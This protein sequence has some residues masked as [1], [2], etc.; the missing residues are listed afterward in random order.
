[1]I[2]KKKIWGKRQVHTKG[3]CATQIL[4]YSPGNIDINICVKP[5]KYANSFN[6]LIT[7]GSSYMF[8]HHIAILR[9]RS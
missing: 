9:K 8:L 4:L 3:K 1:M 5:K 2:H 7:Y 6:L